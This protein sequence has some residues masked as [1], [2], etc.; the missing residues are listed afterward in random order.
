M[1]PHGRVLSH[2]RSHE[3]S[4][5]FCFMDSDILATGDFMDELAPHLAHYTG[6]FSCPPV[7]CTD[8]DQVLPRDLTRV[9]GFHWK[10]EI[11]TCLGSSYFA[12]YSNHVLAE[13]AR[14]TGVGFEKRR[15]GD[16]PTQYRAQLINEGLARE[17]YD[18]GKLLNL[19]LLIRGEELLFTTVRSLHH[20][21]GI[22]RQVL[23]ERE[24][25]PRRMPNK[26]SILR[27]TLRTLWRL[28]APSRVADQGTQGSMPTDAELAAHTISVRKRTTSRYFSELLR[29]LHQDHPLPSAPGIGDA[30]IEE[31]IGQVTA[32]IVALYD[33]FA[34][35]LVR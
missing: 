26:Q 16:V 18:T 4:D 34:G 20:I 15:W 28:T 23:R 5:L 10:T 19:L 11:G 31:R 24:E 30:M 27:R 35:E 17:V 14:D 8:E 13:A 9:R 22:A 25:H 2:L 32:H 12:I 1:Q 21:G 29:C 7:W 33:E 3:R 6:L